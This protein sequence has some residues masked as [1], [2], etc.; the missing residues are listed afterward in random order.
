MIF[1]SAA[2]STA[3]EASS[4]AFVSAGEDSGSTVAGGAVG[5]GSEGVG[6]EAGRGGGTDFFG[7]GV[8]CVGEVGVSGKSAVDPLSERAGASRVGSGGKTASVEEAA[9]AARSDTGREIT[10]SERVATSAPRAS[11]AIIPE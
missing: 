11:A 9:G 8:S 10:R 2:R 5:T 6:G 3:A 7:A 1:T 4:A